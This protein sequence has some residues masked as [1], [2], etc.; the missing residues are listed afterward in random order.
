M[1]ERTLWGIH[2]GSD[3]EAD[4]LFRKNKLIAIC[5][6]EMGDLSKQKDREEYKQKHDEVYPDSKVGTTRNAAGVLYRFVHEI[7]IDDLVIYPSGPTKQIYIG[8]V[9]GDYEYRPD[10]DTDF[11]NQRKVRWIKNLPRT[12][13]S[14][15]ALYEIGSAAAL[16]QV[17][18]YADDFIAA[19]EG[20][21]EP[22][23]PDE[24]TA[25]ITEGIETQTRDF[26]L[27]Q[28]YKH[29]KGEALEDL[30]VHLLEKMGYHARKMAKNKPSVDVIAHKDELGAELPIIKCQVK[31]EG[32]SIKLEPI[33]KLYS[34]VNT[35]AGE[36]GLF[37]A[38]SDYN[39]KARRFADAKP[40]LRLIDGYE[41]VDILISHY[42]ELDT[43]FKNAIPLKKVFLPNATE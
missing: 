26:I 41:L 37:V 9:I 25:I 39:D 10:V 7:Q 34:N 17:R 35:G 30:I 43:P 18:N 11:P 15:Q 21:P 29:Y 5:W 28:L 40:N 3:W 14:Q 13:F 27:K 38:L 33:E 32:S 12:Y 8:K 22:T 23:E 6:A 1:N 4:E 31:T 42:D 16:F 20:G 19:L 36:F 2:A 24:E